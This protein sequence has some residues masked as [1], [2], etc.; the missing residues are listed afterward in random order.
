MILEMTLKRLERFYE[1]EGRATAVLT[2]IGLKPGWT[3]LTGSG[4]L[5]GSAFRFTGHH[6][7]YQMAGPDLDVIKGLIGRDLFDVV[8]E[9]AGSPVIQMRSI[10]VAALS[11]LSQPFLTFDALEK[12]GIIAKEDQ[13]YMERAV[14]TDDVVTLIGYGGMVRNLLGKCRELHVADMRSP[15]SLLTVLIGDTIEYE[16]KGLTVHRAEDDEALL[17]RSDV[18]V[19]TASSIVN[20][21]MDDLLTF[22]APARIKAVYG[23]SASIIPDV[24][25]EKGITFV[26]S[27]HVIDPDRFVDSMSR[28]DNMESALRKYQRYQ[29]MYPSVT[30]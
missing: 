23:P 24:L 19:M 18:V 16:P 20:G 4:G 17:A 30:R 21:T 27:H 15:E 29:V 3:V 28:D 5:C 14:D 8:R 22:A 11:A 25:F 13:N 2:R 12:R 26:L 10:A 6:D 7:V 1:A 9:H